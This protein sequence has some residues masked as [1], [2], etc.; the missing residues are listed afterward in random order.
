MCSAQPPTQQPVVATC[1]KDPGVRE[2]P[3]HA[4]GHGPGVKETPLQSA[5][6]LLPY[7]FPLEPHTGE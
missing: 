1:M 7:V 6:H 3:C 2:T 4:G 5:W